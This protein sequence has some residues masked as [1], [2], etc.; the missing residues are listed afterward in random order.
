[1]LKQNMAL[2]KQEYESRVGKNPDLNEI[3]VTNSIN[4]NRRM[5]DTNT[6]LNKAFERINN[7]E[8]DY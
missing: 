2:V 8:Q 3:A 1:M 6:V 4:L 7:L 5:D